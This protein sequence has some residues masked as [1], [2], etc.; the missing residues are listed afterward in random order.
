MKRTT[1]LTALATL[2]LSG[3]TFHE[4]FHATAVSIPLL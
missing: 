3:A 2:G 4:P 1:V